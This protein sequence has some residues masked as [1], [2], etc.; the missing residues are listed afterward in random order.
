[1]KNVNKKLLFP[2]LAGIT[3][4]SCNNDDD[5]KD[6]EVD[7][8]RRIILSSYVT[9]GVEPRLQD[10]QIEKGQDLSLFIT[11]YNTI[12]EVIYD[13]EQIIANGDGGFAG[14]DMY[15]PIDGRNVDFY[16]IHP[17]SLE[18]NL[19]DPVD[20]TIETDQR[21]E[22]NYLNSDLL[23][24]NRQISHVVTTLSLWFFPTS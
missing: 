10:E 19:I 5:C 24:A 15:F 8:S 20:F 13:N 11:P 21:S 22:K 2:L 1:M 7:E 17:Y 18:A 23:F 12:G 6:C 3:L 9:M 16:A 4:I 14:R